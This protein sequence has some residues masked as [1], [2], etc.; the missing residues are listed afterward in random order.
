[1]PVLDLGGDVDD[2]AR[3]ELACR[4]APLLVPA[5]AVG[6]EQHLARA[7]VDVPVVAAPG[8]ERHV[9]GTEHVVVDEAVEIALADEVP[10]VGVVRLAKAE[11]AAVLGIACHVRS[12]RRGWRAGRS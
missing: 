11:E 3:P 6:H 8:L 9:R 1:M 10:R 2:V 12:F 7:V 5:A 4:L